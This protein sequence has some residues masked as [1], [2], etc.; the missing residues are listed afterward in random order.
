MKAGTLFRLRPNK[1]VYRAEATDNAA[2]AA[3]AA[4]GRAELCRRMPF[5][6]TK[7]FFVK[8]TRLE[9]RRAEKEGKEILLYNKYK[10]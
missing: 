4:V 10:S 8:L 5:C 1:D 7:V 2:C 9:Q 6:S 3:C